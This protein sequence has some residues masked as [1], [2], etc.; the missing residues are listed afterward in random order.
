MK[1]LRVRKGQWVYYQ[2]SASEVAQC[3]FEKWCVMRMHTGG[4]DTN[5]LGIGAIVSSKWRYSKLFHPRPDWGL[6]RGQARLRPYLSLHT[7]WNDAYWG[8]NPIQRPSVKKV[9]VNEALC[10]R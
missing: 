8:K 5:K 9:R 3:R 7:N 4:D 1:T 6:R 10:F 2:H